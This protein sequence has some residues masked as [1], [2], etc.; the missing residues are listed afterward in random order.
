LKAVV[1]DASGAAA[2]VLPDER[3]DASEDL[4]AHACMTDS[5]F[6]A[7]P[8]WPWEMGNILL[9]AKARKRIAPDAVE[10]ALQTLAKARIQLDPAPDLHRQKQVA[11]L[12]QTHDLTYYDA[13]YLELVLRLNGQLASRDRQLLSAAAACGIVCLSF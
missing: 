13:S 5:G 2:W 1:I 3:S 11:R 12:A 10:L 6:Q 8:I 9:M 7:P 4:F